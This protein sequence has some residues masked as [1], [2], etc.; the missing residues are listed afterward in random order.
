ML[1]PTDNNLL[2]RKLGLFADNLS[3]QSKSTKEK[4]QDLRDDAVEMIKKFAS[5]YDSSGFKTTVDSF[6]NTIK[7]VQLLSGYSATTHKEEEVGRRLY[8][9]LDTVVKIIGK[10]FNHVIE[11][12]YDL[13]SFRAECIEK[14][15]SLDRRIKEAKTISAMILLEPRKDRIVFKHNNAMD[16][17]LEELLLDEELSQAAREEKT[18]KIKFN[19]ERTGNYN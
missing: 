1:T 5:G 6:S 9:D 11:I 19:N 4:M 15:T 13:E 2:R 18:L 3:E 17:Q 16:A 7:S 14:R 10:E 12:N 8:E